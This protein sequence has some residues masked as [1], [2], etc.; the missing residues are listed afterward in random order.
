MLFLKEKFKSHI[1]WHKGLNNWKM[2][3]N[4]ITNEKQSSSIEIFE[5]IQSK[6]HKMNI[7]GWFYW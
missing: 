3:E 6:E 1:Q 4:T 5:R 2:S 7:E